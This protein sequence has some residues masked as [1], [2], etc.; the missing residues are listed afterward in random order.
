MVLC[1][2]VRIPI[3]HSATYASQGLLNVAKDIRAL[4]I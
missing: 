1:T 3:G 4:A 2:D